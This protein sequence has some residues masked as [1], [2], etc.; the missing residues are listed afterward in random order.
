MRARHTLLASF[1]NC[2]RQEWQNSGLLENTGFTVIESRTLQYRLCH[3]L[4]NYRPTHFGD[5]V[6]KDVD[7][8]PHFGIS[9]TLDARPRFYQPLQFPMP[10]PL[11]P[12]KDAEGKP[13]QL[14]I[15]AQQWELAPH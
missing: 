10:M 2:G 3:S 9:L 6:V 13:C 5:K 8:S 7:W 1:F 12:H 11:I 15:M 14:Q 4:T